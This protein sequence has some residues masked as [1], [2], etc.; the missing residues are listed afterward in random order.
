MNDCQFTMALERPKWNQPRILRKEKTTQSSPFIDQI[1]FDPR[2]RLEASLLHFPKGKSMLLPLLGLALFTLCVGSI[3]IPFDQGGM[4]FNRNILSKWLTP[5]IHFLHQNS[6]NSA[7]WYD[8][9]TNA[10]F[11]VSI[12]YVGIFVAFFF[13]RPVSSALQNLDLINS[14]V[15]M[16]PKR[17]LWDK[18]INVISTWLVIESCLHRSF[19][20]NNPK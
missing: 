4:D 2:L 14:F 13:Y 16:R 20:F 19:L 1:S 17:L 15:K 8:F 11:S 12:A 9:L 6:N 3:G 10:T 5:S 7:D 18:I